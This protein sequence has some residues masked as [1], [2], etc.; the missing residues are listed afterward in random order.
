MADLSIVNNLH[1]LFYYSGVI[2]MKL[3]LLLPFSVFNFP[4]FL[5]VHTLHFVLLANKTISCSRP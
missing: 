4:I 5:N 2:S 3:L 1:G